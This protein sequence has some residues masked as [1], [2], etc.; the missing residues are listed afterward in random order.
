[1]H[2]SVN[3]AGIASMCTWDFKISDR[4]SVAAVLPELG[5]T[6]DA[7]FFVMGEKFVQQ[8]YTVF[9]SDKSQMGFGVSVYSDD[10]TGPWILFASDPNP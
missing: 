9:D 4:N 1:M 3:A 8:Y 7:N 2:N 10:S 5:A 6:G